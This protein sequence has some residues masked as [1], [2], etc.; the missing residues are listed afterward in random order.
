[1]AEAVKPT[2]VIR[3]TRDGHKPSVLCHARSSAARA[4]HPMR[5][6]GCS[7]GASLAAA[8]AEGKVAASAVHSSPRVSFSQ[9]FRTSGVQPRAASGVASNGSFTSGACRGCGHLTHGGSGRRGYGLGV[10]GVRRLS[11]QGCSHARRGAVIRGSSNKRMQP[12]AGGSGGADL[13]PAPAPATADARR[14]ADNDNLSQSR[15]PTRSH[16]RRM[17]LLARDIIVVG[18]RQ[19]H[20]E[21]PSHE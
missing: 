17:H 10:R 9:P 13:A 20:Y 1:M 4:R 21:G 16:P 8:R 14:S 5:A 2:L 11:R 18:E 6:L 15:L 19:V 3:G 7:R 12:T